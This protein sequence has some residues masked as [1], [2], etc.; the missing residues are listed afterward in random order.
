VCSRIRGIAAAV[1]LLPVCSIGLAA[2]AQTESRTMA[3]GQVLHLGHFSSV[4]PDCTSKGTETVRISNAPAHGVV[5]MRTELAFSNFATQKQ[6]E[7]H[8]VH[9]V[10][11]E[12]L[13]EHGYLG[14][15]TVGLDVIDPSGRERMRTYFITVK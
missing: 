10:T 12:Y 8:K 4:N 14:S 7:A 9:G 15:D 5:R 1:L 11:V 13:P 3:A 6:C 2:D